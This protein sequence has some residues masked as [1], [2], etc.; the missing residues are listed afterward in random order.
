MRCRPGPAPPTE[1]R[2]TAMGGDRTTVAALRGVLGS[3]PGSGA[4]DPNA[5]PQR[6]AGRRGREETSDRPD[7][8]CTESTALASGM[9]LIVNITTADRERGGRSRHRPLPARVK[10]GRGLC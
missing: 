4:A 9:E 10:E 3:P 6:P 1:P 5:I 2:L 7:G 8:T